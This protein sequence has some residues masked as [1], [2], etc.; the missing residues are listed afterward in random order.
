MQFTQIASEGGLLPYPVLRNSIKLWPAKRREIIVDF[1]HYQNGGGETGD[2]DEIYLVNVLTMNDGRK[3]ESNSGSCVPMIKFVIRGGKP[4]DKSVI[5]AKLRELPD[6]NAA[7]QPRSFELQRGGAGGNDPFVAETQWLINDM[8]F[9]ACVS[10]ASP[11]RGDPLGAGEIWKVKNGG[12]GW[13]HPMHFHQE[14]H[15]ILSRNGEPTP[16]LPI[17][18]AVPADIDDFGKEDTI[19]LGPGDSVVMF[20][21]FRTFVGPYVAH[22]HNLAHEDHTMMF[23]WEIAKP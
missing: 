8:P 7:G 6:I 3:P 9:Q 18:G 5:P 4:V 2:G 10:L 14:E 15:Q 11:R 22:C 23:G 16:R 20:R 17:A 12:G 19:P 21:R 1:T 13:V